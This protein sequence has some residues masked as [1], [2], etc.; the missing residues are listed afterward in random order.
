MR[1][2]KAIAELLTINLYFFWINWKKFRT[3]SSDGAFIIRIIP[4]QT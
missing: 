1:K 2:R 4:P 3:G